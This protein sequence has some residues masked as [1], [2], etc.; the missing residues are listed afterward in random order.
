MR[1]PERQFSENN[2]ES[3]KRAELE[4]LCEGAPDA[5]YLLSGISEITNPETQE[6]KYKP[7]SYADVDW[8]G[9]MTGGKARA[10]AVVELAKTFPEANVAVNS[11]TFNVRNPE[12]PTDAEVMAEYVERKGVEPERVLKQDRSTTTFTELIELIKYIADYNWQHPVVVAGETQKARAEEM[13]R[14]IATLQ[15]P[16]GAWKDPEFREALEKVQQTSP[17]ITIVSSEDILPLRDERY[18]KV[19]AQAKETETWKVREKLDKGAVED[20]RQGRYW[21]K[22]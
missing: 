15:D 21:Q 3:E 7:G 20:L 18:A 5:I 8:N 19:I 9:Y 4:H 14:Q 1:N 12:A 17:K 2:I 22:K 13:L 11:N 10:L 16:A 6:K